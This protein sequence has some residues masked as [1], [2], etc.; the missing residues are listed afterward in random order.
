M[1]IVLIIG[2][3][4]SS[5]GYILS[6]LGYIAP[7]LGYTYIIRIMLYILYIL[8]FMSFTHLISLAIFNSICIR[9]VPEVLYKLIFW[10]L[11]NEYVHNLYI[12]V[13]IVA[14]QICLQRPNCW[15]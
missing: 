12:Y 1:Y 15:T 9:A 10:K 13:L 11:N 6:T 7:A 14:V 4:S 8:G 2:F 5:L 3:I